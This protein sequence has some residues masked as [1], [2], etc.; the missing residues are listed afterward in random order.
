MSEDLI[1]NAF[2]DNINLNYIRRNQIVLNA[3]LSLSTLY[4]LLDIL[5]W[6]FILQSTNAIIDGDFLFLYTLRIRPVISVL[7]LFAN[8]CSF[9]LTSKANDLIALSIIE[10]NAVLFNDGY[11]YHFWANLLFLF[12]TCIAVISITVR[13]VLRY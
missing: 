10:E 8:L 11:K 13:V 2:T 9:F 12:A 6:Y 7:V 4:C 5:N 1:T 3:L